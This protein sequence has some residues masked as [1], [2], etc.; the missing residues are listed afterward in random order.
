MTMSKDRHHETRQKAIDII[1][2]ITGS[3]VSMRWD[4]LSDRDLCVL[5]YAVTKDIQGSIILQQE[6]L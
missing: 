1:E 4:L 3:M 5:Y 6:L 2:G